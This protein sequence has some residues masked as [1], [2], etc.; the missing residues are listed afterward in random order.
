MDLTPYVEGLRRDLI[1]AAGT[2]DAQVREAAER[3]TLALAPAARLALMEALSQAAA[4][5][6][7]EMSSGSVDVRLAG[8]Q[9]DFIVT[10]DRDLPA[11][12]EPPAPPP[13]PEPDE[14]SAVA[15]VS[16]R[17]PEPV[18]AR[19][20][21]LATTAGQ[22]LNTW[23]VNAIRSAT[24]EQAIRVDVDL[25]SLPL[26]DQIWPGRSRGARRMTGWV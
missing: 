12:P 15:R 22:S 26:G 11:P 10:G 21:E 6:T 25:S 14:E 4:E 24:Q 18:K 1:D 3:L 19:A 20:E 9:L 7:S 13:S 2:G 8:R 17:I 23:L 5:I 16:L